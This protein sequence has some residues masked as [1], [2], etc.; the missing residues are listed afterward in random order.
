MKETDQANVN[1]EPNL[2]KSITG[3]PEDQI[4]RERNYQHTQRMDR[5]VNFIGSLVTKLLND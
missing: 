2:G 5:Q 1:T 4:V 3:N